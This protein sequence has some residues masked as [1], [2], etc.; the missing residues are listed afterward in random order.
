[1]ALNRRRSTRAA[2]ALAGL[3]LVAAGLTPAT[4]LPASPSDGEASLTDEFDIWSAPEAAPTSDWEGVPSDTG[5]WIVRLAGPSVAA[6]TASLEARGTASDSQ[7]ASFDAQLEAKHSELLDTIDATLGRDVNVEFTYRNVLN[8]M[9]VQISETE[10]QQL[11][12]LP[13][14]VEVYPDTIREMD[15][16]VSHEVILSDAV[17]EG[18]TG[19]GVETSGEGIVIGFIDSGVNPFHPSFAETDGEGYTHENPLGEGVYLGVCADPSSTNYED[20]C[21]DKLI[22]AYNLNAGSPSA[23]DA[24]D[25]G[26]HVGSTIAGNRHE[27]EV[28]IG[29]STFTRFVQGVAPRA[30]AISYLV[31]APGCPGAASIAAVDHAIDDGVDVLNYSISGSDFPWNDPVD[32]AFRDAAAAGINE[33]GS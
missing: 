17:W 16:D 20:I 12:E 13:G 11:R 10:A 25:H 6:Y 31:C 9:A 21:N 24:D 32:L 19:S 29:G 5:L 18:D 1:M 30:N 7:V 26:S 14:V 8:G 3:A 23:I 27:A 28:N 4:A 33:V 22:G 2:S 15:T